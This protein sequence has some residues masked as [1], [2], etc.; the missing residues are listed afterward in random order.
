MT[1]FDSM[2]SH[3]NYM[4]NNESVHDEPQKNI[5]DKIEELNFEKSFLKRAQLATE[6]VT[7]IFHLIFSLLHPQS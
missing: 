7:H 5:R 2:N 6:V 4:S 1:F 3:D